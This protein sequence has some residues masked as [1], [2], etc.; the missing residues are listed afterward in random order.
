MKNEGLRTLTSEEEQDLGRRTLGNEA[1]SERE[2]FWEVKRQD[3]SREIVENEG[4]DCTNR[5]YRKS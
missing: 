2:R 4:K 5:I 1:L 3:L